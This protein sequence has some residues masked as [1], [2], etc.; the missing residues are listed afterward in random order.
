MFISS[1]QNNPHQSFLTGVLYDCFKFTYEY[2]NEK[3]QG[4]QMLR[5]LWCLK[6]MIQVHLHVSFSTISFIKGVPLK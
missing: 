1:E 3:D 2:L 5:M 6:M 4:S